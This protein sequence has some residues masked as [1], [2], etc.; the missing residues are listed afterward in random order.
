[1]IMIRNR[2]GRLFVISAPSGTGKTSVVRKLLSA[3]PD[4]IESI[5]YTTRLPRPNERN[6]IDYFFV[7]AKHFETLKSEGFFAEC[8]EVHGSFYGTPIGPIEE[9]ISHGKKVVLDV[10]VQGGM[11]LKKIFP[12]AI[13]IFLLPPNEVELTRRL[14]GRGTEEESQ[15]ARRL[16]NAKHE[17]T[18]KD[19]YDHRIVNDDLDAAVRELADFIRKSA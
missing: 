4:L 12:D 19:L 1:M 13:T 17:M 2:K 5:S 3:N 7:D 11:T 16:S 15:I 10:D 6:G 9:A 14:R 18:F 8:A